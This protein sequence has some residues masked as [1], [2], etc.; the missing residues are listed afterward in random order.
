MLKEIIRAW[1]YDA[2]K[3]LVKEAMAEPHRT[4][5][6]EPS[7]IRENEVKLLSNALKDMLRKELLNTTNTKETKSVHGPSEID[8]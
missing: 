2:E 1:G 7:E 5:C 6:A 8:K 4:V 3:V